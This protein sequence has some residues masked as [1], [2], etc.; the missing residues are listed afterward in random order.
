MQRADG[1]Q[2]FPERRDLSG[3]QK[4]GIERPD[5]QA[6]LQEN[7]TR[8]VQRLYSFQNQ[9]GGWG[10]WFASESNP[11]LSAYAL[12]ALYNAKQAGFA[13]DDSVMKRAQDFL[14]RTFEKQPDVKATYTFNERAF[15]IF[16]LT[17]IGGNYTS[18]AVTL[19]DARVNL[20]HYGKAYLLMAMQKLKLPQAQTLQSELTSAAIPS[21]TGAH[22][23]E[24]QTDYWTMNTNTRSTALVI[25][26]LARADPKNATLAN[27]VR[28]L[29]IAQRRALADDSRDSVVSAGID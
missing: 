17:E 19:F 3:A 1:Q 12:L 2:I 10:W 20:A 28:W 5:L 21:A 4:S 26:A 6:N 18:R 13:V 27:A 11:T 9:D 25:M 14:N 29:M 7:V 23:E 16:V 8:E 22:W 15:V 24:A